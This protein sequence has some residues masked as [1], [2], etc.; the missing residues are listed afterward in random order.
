MANVVVPAVASSTR[1]VPDAPTNIN[2]TDVGTS[3]AYDN[4]AATVSYSAPTFD[5]KLPITSYSIVGSP[6]GLATDTDGSP[7]TVTGLDT[8]PSGTNHTFTVA[9][10]NAVG[11]SA[12][13]SASSSTLITSV[14]AA[15]TGQAAS[16]TD[17]NTVSLS[18]TGQNTG[19]KTVTGYSITST[20]SLS[21]TYSGS[22]ATSPISV[23]GNFVANS[24]GAPTI[25]TCTRVDNS[26]ANVV[27]TAPSAPGGQSYTFT[28]AAI[29]AN[30]TGS[31]A[32]TGSVTPNPGTITGYTVEGRRVDTLASI[33]LSY[34]SSDTTTPIPVT[35]SFVAGT[36]AAPTGV[37][38]TVID[39]GTVDVNFTPP[40]T[41][42]GVQYEFRLGANN[43]AAN[44]GTYSGW[45]NDVS[46]NNEAVS[47]YTI[48]ARRADNQQALSPISYNNLDL[49]SPIR[50]TATF[51]QIAPGAPTNLSITAD[52]TSDTFDLNFT[53]PSSDGDVGYQ[54]RIRGNNSNNGTYSG[55]TTA[56]T[57]N[58][59][60]IVGYTITTSIGLTYNNTDTTS[61]ITVSGA[62]AANTSYTFTIAARNSSLTGAGAT[63]SYTP[64]PRRLCTSAQITVGCCTVTTQCFYFGAG[65]TCATINFT[66]DPGAC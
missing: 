54:F 34:S 36:P 45:S 49:T 44:P 43:S 30:G 23:D 25:G 11:S 50:V 21:L 60:S 46:I 59:A 64:D 39:T 56:V 48:E 31:G 58:P 27:F 20:P 4:G 29:N 7:A 40:P 52:G 28:L 57:P 2:A 9:A 41:P 38:A 65:S 16:V 33:A 5:G 8:S 26:T 35:G 13:S 19:G 47:S 37:S 6:G 53:P 3:R 63:I 24:P 66:A 62:F 42:N 10:T 18:W 17:T 15:P 32:T 12:A 22:D 55:W 1:R 51:I 14:P 61:P